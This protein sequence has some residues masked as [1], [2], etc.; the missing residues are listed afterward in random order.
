MIEREVMESL[1]QH[2]GKRVKVSC[3]Q[4]YRPTTYTRILEEVV[5]FEF[6]AIQGGTAPITISF[7][8]SS[9]AVKR[10]E[11]ERVLYDNPLITDDYD[12]W[13]GGD[14][15]GTL[16]EL[17]ARTFGEEV[18]SFLHQNKLGSLLRKIEAAKLD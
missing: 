1:K 6:I 12:L 5:D 3:I 2:I 17:R 18:A 14:V 4:N 13:R 9:D 16:Q 10:I 11:G 8:G 15:D 7:I